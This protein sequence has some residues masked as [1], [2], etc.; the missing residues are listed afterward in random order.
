MI[1][2][3][4]DYIIEHHTRVSFEFVADLSVCFFRVCGRLICVLL[5][6]LWQTN[7][8]EHRGS[9]ICSIICSIIFV[10]RYVHSTLLRVWARWGRQDHNIFGGK[11]LGIRGGVFSRVDK[12]GLFFLFW[13]KLVC[14]IVK[15]YS[16]SFKSTANGYRQTTIQKVKTLKSMEEKHPW[17]VN[18]TP[19]F[20]IQKSRLA[21]I[22][23][24]AGG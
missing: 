13:M 16:Q 18:L 2:H 24:N 21:T 19:F 15:F 20:D 22:Q 9:I 17:Y 3:V 10:N 5:Q 23:T 4:L 14:K 8:I 11:P 1:E 6:S 12:N 7:M